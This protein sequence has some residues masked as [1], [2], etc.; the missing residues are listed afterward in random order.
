VDRGVDRA[1]LL[2]NAG[3]YVWFG[4]DRALE[5]LTGYFIEKALSVDNIFVFLVIFSY[6]AVPAAFQHRVLFWGILSAL[7]MRGIFILL[8]AALLQ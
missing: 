2:F 6:F 8:G 4:P 5:F 7:L 1:G 3:L